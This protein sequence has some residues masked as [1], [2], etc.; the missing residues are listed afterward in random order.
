MPSV[1]E[2]SPMNVY[3]QENV[4]RRME[5]AYEVGQLAGLIRNYILTRDER[6]LKELDRLAAKALGYEPIMERKND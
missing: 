1:Q 3:H 4:T 5:L 6:D 2:D